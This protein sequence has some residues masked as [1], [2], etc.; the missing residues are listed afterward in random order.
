MKITHKLLLTIY[1][2]ILAGHLN[3]VLA[4]TAEQQEL[5][6]ALEMMKGQG[7]DPQQLQ[8]ME[9]MLKNIGQMEARKKDSRISRELQAFEAETTGYGTAQVEVEGKRYDLTVTKCEVKDSKSGNFTIKARQVPGMD[10]GELAVYSDGVKLSRS[11]QFSTRSTPPANYYTENP[12]LEFDGKTLDWTGTVESNAR[13]VSLTLRL[14]CGAEAIYFDKPSRPRPDT[15][16]NTLTLYL[17]SETYEFEAGRCSLKAYRTGNLMVDFEATTTGTFR[18][19]PAIILLTKSHGVGLEGRSAGYFHNFDLL[20]GELSAEQRRLSP[21]DVKK[22]LSEVVE[23]YQTRELLA[24]QKKYD[25]DTWN[26]VPPDKLNEVMEASSKEMSAFMDK[27]DAMRY[28]EATSHG[29]VVTIDGRDVMFRG[30][31][32]STS[33]ASRAPEFVDLSALTEAFVTC[34]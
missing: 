15:P 23:T 8:Q 11:V 26:N 6:Q 5:N 9:N 33:D 7:M 18:G 29:G 13:K 27:A 30:L 24:H 20:L 17:G 10:D 16:A 22:Q 25:K 2:F 1:L 14:D 12:E 32:M 28:P 31:A 19:R 34:Q 3:A 4:D 21:L